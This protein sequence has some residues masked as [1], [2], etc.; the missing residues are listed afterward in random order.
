MSGHD[1][2]ELVSDMLAEIQSHRCFQCMAGCALLLK[3]GPS[4][5]SS[6]QPLL[7]LFTGHSSRMLV[8]WPGRILYAATDLLAA[9]V[10]Q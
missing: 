10:G 9:R 3:G 7:S 5:S 2:L 4:L 6:F 1:V 8:S